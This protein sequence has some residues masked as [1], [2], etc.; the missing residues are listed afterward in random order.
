LRSTIEWKYPC[1]FR[2]WLPLVLT[3]STLPAVICLCL[4]CLV[5]MAV[6][7][8]VRVGRV[9]QAG[10]E[11]LLWQVVEGFWMPFLTV[12]VA[13]IALLVVG[14]RMRKLALRSCLRLG[15][16]PGCGYEVGALPA[17]ADGCRVC[18][19]CGAAWKLDP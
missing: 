1:P 5:G 13:L 8:F 4:V 14:L 2:T 18:S 6:F 19:E 7:T 3:D 15:F 17:E 10:R 16:C 12:L 11:E 9:A